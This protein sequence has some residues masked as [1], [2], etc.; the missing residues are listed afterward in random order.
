MLKYQTSLAEQQAY[1]KKSTESKLVSIHKFGDHI[2]GLIDEA[3]EEILRLS[4]HLVAGRPD[5]AKSR[6]FQANDRAT[7]SM[8]ALSKLSI[9]ELGGLQEH[10]GPEYRSLVHMPVNLVKL[11]EHWTNNVVPFSKFLFPTDKYN[12]TAGSNRL[13]EFKLDAQAFN[14][15]TRCNSREALQELKQLLFDHDGDPNTPMPSTFT[16]TPM[17]TLRSS[18]LQSVTLRDAARQKAGIPHSARFYSFCNPVVMNCDGLP[19]PL[20]AYE[21]VDKRHGSP[22]DALKKSKVLINT[23]D[24]FVQW[25]CTGAFVYFDFAFDIVAVNALCFDELDPLTSSTSALYYGSPSP[26]PRMAFEPLFDLGR[27]WPVTVTGQLD[28]GFTH[29]TFVKPSEFLGDH[30]FTNSGGFAYLH[31]DDYKLLKMED[32]GSKELSLTG[33]S[34]SRFYPVVRS[35][36]TVDHPFESD[37][38]DKDSGDKDSGIRVPRKVPKRELHTLPLKDRLEIVRRIAETTVAVRP[39]PHDAPLHVDAFSGGVGSQEKAFSESNSEKYMTSGVGAAL[40][41]DGHLAAAGLAFTLGHE[42]ERAIEQA[43][44]AEDTGDARHDELFKLRLEG[45]RLTKESLDVLCKRGAVYLCKDEKAADFLLEVQR[46]LAYVLDEPAVEAEVTGNDGGKAKRDTGHNGQCLKDFVELDE[47]KHAKLS[48]AEVAALRLY[49]SSTFRVINGP[50][51]AGVQPHPF[52][53]TTLLIYRALKKLRAKHMAVLKF[54]TRYLWRGMRDRTVTEE[55]M[56]KGGVELGCMSTTSDLAVVAG[57]A[58]SQAPLLL[59]IKIDNPMEMG[60]DIRWL[61]MFPGEE[62]VLFPPLTFLKPMFKQQVRNGVGI[63]VTVKPSFPS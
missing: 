56:L 13:V 42:N 15:G 48:P 34:R 12:L 53:F 21:F 59:R 14:S 25:L 24:P 4:L 47:A 8:S 29:F 18:P 62:E 41:G 55:F 38:V 40:Y 33:S 58:R 27:W 51:R 43:L 16:N 28:S 46:N 36:P 10:A 20:D 17:F 39:L 6:K 26:L 5:D 52:S 11:D 32:G 22:Y 30:I 19:V 61:S 31:K 7:W 3:D 45:E 1:L 57:Y 9:A 54:Q 35:L 63:V 23:A 50:L 44:S 37:Y 60:A 2:T 49:T